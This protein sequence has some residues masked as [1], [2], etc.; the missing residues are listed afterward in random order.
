M[1]RD[2][3]TQKEEAIF[4]LEQSLTARMDALISEYEGVF[5]LVDLLGCLEV[6]KH[7][8][9]AQYWPHYRRHE[10]DE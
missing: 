3:V 2:A 7:K 8:V 10:D 6:L 1:S 5:T 4:K 9:M